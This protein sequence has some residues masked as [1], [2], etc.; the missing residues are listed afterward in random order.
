MDKTPELKIIE[1][2][3]KFNGDIV[4][5]ELPIEND[6]LDI[7]PI[8]GESSSTWLILDATGALHRLNCDEARCDIIGRI[9]IIA[10]PGHQPWCDHS[11]TNRLYVSNAG[12]FA[13]VVNDYGKQGVVVSLATS[14]VTMNLYGGDYHCET[15]PFSF[16]FVEHNGRT[17]VLHRTDWNRLDISDAANGDLLTE[18]RI[19]PYE[20]GKQ[21]PEHY[22]DYFHGGLFVSPDGTLTADD[23][24]IWHPVGV[25][26][27][28]SISAWLAGSLWESEDGSS[29]LS[30]CNRAYYWDAA[31][32][33]I[34][35][36]RIA[37]GGL[38]DD[39]EEMVDGAR[40]FDVEKIEESGSWRIAKEILS[41]RG[42]RGKF[43]SDGQKLFSVNEHGL[44]I[45]DAGDGARVGVIPELQATHQHL[46][47]REMVEL[48]GKTMRRWQ[49]GVSEVENF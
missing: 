6:I 4:E 20:T 39:E 1:R 28:F 13:A 16:S 32:C 25:P 27:V 30:L 24:W 29:M 49:F 19:A 40:I 14:H 35:S 2:P 23:G 9:P 36:A 3:G 17:L 38:G 34:D 8:N 21:R 44:N 31:M 26:T 46:G 15:V 22:L 18:R 47:A 41:F 37:V 48:R 10:E 33:W 5:T 45:W 7:A 42:P 11:L 43:F 12:L